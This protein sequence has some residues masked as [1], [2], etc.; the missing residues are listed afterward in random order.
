MYANPYNQSGDDDAALMC[1]SIIIGVSMREKFLHVRVVG[2][3]ITGREKVLNQF[4]TV[5]ILGSCDNSCRKPHPGNIGKM[6]QVGPDLRR[7]IVRAPG[8]RAAAGLPPI[9]D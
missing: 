6:M 3:P 8:F 2:P 4:D 7:A 1:V 9:A 5:S